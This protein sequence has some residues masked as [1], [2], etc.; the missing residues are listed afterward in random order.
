MKR[1]KTLFITWGST[2]TQKYKHMILNK[3]FLEISDKLNGSMKDSSYTLFK[4]TRGMVQ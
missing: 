2:D 3:L 4:I 1:K